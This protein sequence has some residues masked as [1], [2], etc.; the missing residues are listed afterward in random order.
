MKLIGSLVSIKKLQTSQSDL[1]GLVEELE[2]TENDLGYRSCS[3]CYE[4]SH[5]GHKV[6][7]R[8]FQAIHEAN[9]SAWLAEQRVY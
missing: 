9:F 4:A 3:I 2:F 1:L 8:I 5:K 6:E 7:C